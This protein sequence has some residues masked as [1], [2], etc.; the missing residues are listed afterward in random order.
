MYTCVKIKFVAGERGVCMY[1]CV[2]IKFVAESHL[3]F[4]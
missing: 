4:V 1:T 2:K 3:L